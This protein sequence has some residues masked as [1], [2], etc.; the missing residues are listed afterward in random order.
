MKTCPNL[1]NYS[2]I[3]TKKKRKIDDTYSSSSS[4][5]SSSFKDINE[6]S[7]EEV[8]ADTDEG[9]NNCITLADT[10]DEQVCN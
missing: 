3:K 4:S 10:D 6:D 7:N 1:K 9:D 8:Q 5:S 2:K